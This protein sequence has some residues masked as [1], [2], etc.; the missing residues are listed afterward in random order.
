M[1]YADNLQPDPNDRDTWFWSD[2]ARFRTGVQLDAAEKDGWA[3]VAGVPNYGIH[4]RVADLHIGR[5]V[6]T[7]H[8]STPHPG[9]NPARRKAWTN[10]DTQPPVQGQLPLDGQSS[11]PPLSAI[12][13]WHEHDG[14]PEIHIGLPIGP[15]KYQKSPRLHWRVPFPQDGAALDTL[16][17][18]PGPD[19]GDSFIEIDPAWDLPT[20]GEA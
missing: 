11:L 9:R 1:G 5:V 3:I 4:L 17:F 16:R 6:R 12:L 10:F 20:G 14:E 8:G 7:L 2:S 13:D 19:E 15:W 18:E